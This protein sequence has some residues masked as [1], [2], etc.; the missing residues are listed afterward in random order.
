MPGA[1]ASGKIRRKDVPM[2]IDVVETL[3]TVVRE[4]LAVESTDINR[5]SHLIADLGLDSVGFAIAIVAI[6]EKLAVRISER[7]MS[8]CETL[9]DVA[10]LV[11]RCRGTQQRDR[12]DHV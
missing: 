4:D 5:S 6:E 1:T 11:L 7:E 10:D 2:S 3:V 8:E 12:A 9:G